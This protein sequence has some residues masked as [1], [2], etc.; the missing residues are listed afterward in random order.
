MPCLTPRACRARQG[1][2]DVAQRDLRITGVIGRG[3]S[4]VVH[5]A[6]HAPSGTTFA[7]KVIPL[8]VREAVRKRIIAEL[9]CLHAALSCPAIVPLHAAFLSEGSVTIV[10]EYMDRGSLADMLAARTRLQERHLRAVAAR[11]LVGLAYLHGALNIIHRD[12]KPSNLLLNSRGEVKISDFGVSGQLAHGRAECNSWVGTARYMAPERIAGRPYSFSSDCW[13]LGITLLECATG[14]FP[15]AP[16]AECE[17]G[18]PM[19]FWELLAAVTEQPAPCLPPGGGFSATFRDFLGGCVHKTADARLSAAELRA[20][21][22]LTPFGEDDPAGEAGERL[23]SDLVRDAW[24]TG[25]GAR[26]AR[27][28]GT[29]LEPVEE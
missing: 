2:F 11:V 26:A 16:A 13:A 17:G 8:D 23:I 20:H 29:P 27:V 21:A 25:V 14:R 28:P 7:L 6:T 15:Y 4:G 12:L 9:R 5:A 19:D 22:W 3:A 10:L 24:A 1:P 18:P